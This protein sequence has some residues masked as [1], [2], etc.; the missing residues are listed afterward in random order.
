MEGYSVSDYLRELMQERG[1]TQAWLAQRM[2]VSRLTVSELI[3]GR[4]AM[5]A[6]VAVRLEVVLASPS[7]EFWVRLQTESDLA[8]ARRRLGGRRALPR[9]PRFRNTAR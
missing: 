8:E 3:N 9:S 7:A 1:V 2:N 5:T 4:R 6:D